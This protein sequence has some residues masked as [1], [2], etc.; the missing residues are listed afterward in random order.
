MEKEHLT[1]EMEK[2]VE[3]FKRYC[4]TRATEGLI[5]AMQAVRKEAIEDCLEVYVN[6]ANSDSLNHEEP[7]VSYIGAYDVM[8][9]LLRPKE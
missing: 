6:Y 3:V 1:P 8:N 7:V 5:K 9:S 2:R 4:G